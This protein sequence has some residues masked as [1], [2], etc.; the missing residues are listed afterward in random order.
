MGTVP[1]RWGPVCVFIAWFNSLLIMHKAA[2][3]C[4]VSSQHHPHIFS[5]VSVFVR[6]PR[7]Q[8]D[9][10]ASKLPFILSRW[11]LHSSVQPSYQMT[12]DTQRRYVLTNLRS[13]VKHKSWRSEIRRGVG[14]RG[15]WMKTQGRWCKKAE[16]R[17]SERPVFENT[18]ASIMTVETKEVHCRL[19]I[20]T[21]AY[22]RLSITHSAKMK[23][24]TDKYKM[25]ERF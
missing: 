22:V 15:I 16:R 18:R 3:V 4:F 2:F 17:E 25:T 14:L 23:H 10:N 8:R 21:Y 1:A 5:S 19:K 6:T 7:F 24:R 11:V 9:T 12:Q 13:T 20:G